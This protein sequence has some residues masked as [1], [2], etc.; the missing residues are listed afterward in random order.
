MLFS[1]VSFKKMSCPSVFNWGNH[2]SQPTNDQSPVE[3]EKAFLEDGCRLVKIDERKGI[4]ISS[5]WC[6]KRLSVRL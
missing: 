6:R 2:K 5:P 4:E 1:P 3:Q